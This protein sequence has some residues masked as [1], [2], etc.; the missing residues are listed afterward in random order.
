MTTERYEIIVQ[1]SDDGYAWEEYLCR[2]KPSEITR[3]PRRISPY[4]P[5]L[6]WQMWFL[7]FDDFESRGWF[8]EFLYH[9]LKGTPE[10]LQ[11][12]RYNPFPEKPPKYIRAV[13]Y[14]YRFSSRQ[15]K[16]ELGVW[17]Q[18]TFVGQYSPIMMLKKNSNFKPS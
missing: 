8:H 18:R 9:L 2:Y 17:W 6:D 11:L 12:I 3:R 10:V 16:K 14:D 13:M 15:E 1:G 4:Q 7:P 5:R